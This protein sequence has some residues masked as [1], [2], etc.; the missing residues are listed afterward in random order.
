[1]RYAPNS[2]MLAKIFKFQSLLQ[3]SSCAIYVRHIKRLANGAAKALMRLDP[4]AGLSEV[5]T[6][7]R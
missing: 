1:M 4:C 2:H 5:L 7:N 3:V 6:C